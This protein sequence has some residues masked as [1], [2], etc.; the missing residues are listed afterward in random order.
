[1]NKPVIKLRRA[2]GFLFLVLLMSACT[3]K[4]LN[5]PYVEDHGEGKVIYSSFS[6]RPKHL[7]PAKAYSSNEYAI[8]AQVYEPL[9]QYHYLKRPYQL[10]P[11]AAAKMPS[12]S[13]LNAKGE[14]LPDDAD[15]ANIAFSEY[16]LTIKNDIKFQPHPSFNLELHKTLPEGW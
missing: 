6:E 3:D 2:A 15:V 7:D 5:N 12:V 4:A 9:F 14:Y 10:E 13:Y 1:M 11:L 8:I 16:H